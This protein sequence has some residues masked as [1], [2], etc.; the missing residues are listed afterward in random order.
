MSAKELRTCSTRNQGCSA[1]GVSSDMALAGERD[2]GAP[3]LDYFVYRIRVEVGG[4][5]SVLGGLHGPSSPRASVEHAAAHRARVCERLAWL[6]H[7]A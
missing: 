5:T 4:L 7:H 1:S 6:R 3:G 2:A